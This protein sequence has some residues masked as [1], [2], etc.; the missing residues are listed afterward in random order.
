MSCDVS[1]MCNPLNAMFAQNQWNTYIHVVVLQSR[2]CVTPMIHLKKQQLHLQNGVTLNYVRSDFRNGTSVRY[3]NMLVQ[4][5]LYLILLILL[6]LKG[7]E[8]NHY[9][10][11]QC[12]DI[13]KRII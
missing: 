12:V 10:K 1:H 5:D 3:V 4:E 6:I 8:K 11:I 7:E 9:Q 13:H 2:V